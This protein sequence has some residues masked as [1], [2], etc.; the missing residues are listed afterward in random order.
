M[1][2][3]KNRVYQLLEKDISVIPEFINTKSYVH[4]TIYIEMQEVFSSLSRLSENKIKSKNTIMAIRNIVDM[5]IDT[6]LTLGDT[7]I[8]GQ[9]CDYILKK[10]EGY[11]KVAVNLELYETAHNIQ[12]FNRI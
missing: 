1:I 3:E 10:I 7:T 12:T 11:S 4:R 6:I 2:Q 9:A 8:G 5:H